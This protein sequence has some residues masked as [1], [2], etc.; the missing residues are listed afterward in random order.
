MSELLFDTG[1]DE[2]AFG[3][4]N[5]SALLNERGFIASANSAI[6]PSM[7]FSFRQWQFD[8][9]KTGVCALDN[10]AQN[11]HTHNTSSEHAHVYFCGAFDGSKTILDMLDKLRAAHT[12]NSDDALFTATRAVFAACCALGQALRENIP[13]AQIGAGGIFVHFETG[14]ARTE[15]ITL[16]FL[17]AKLFDTASACKG[18]HTYAA[19]QGAWCSKLLTDERKQLLFTQSAIAYCALT[20]HAPFS[21]IDE[22]ERHADERDKQFLRLEHAVNGIHDEVARAVDSALELPH[23][24]SSSAQLVQAAFPLEKLYAELGIGDGN[25]VA[26]PRPN[27]LPENEFKKNVAAYYAAKTRAV[28]RSR[29]IRRNTTLIAGI[30]I[31]CTVAVLLAIL[32]HAG[33]GSKPTARGLASPNVVELFYKGMHT[34]N[35]EL[36]SAMSSGKA[37]RRYTNMVSSMYVVNKARSAYEPTN[38]IVTPEAWLL[39]QSGKTAIDERAVFG[40]TSFVLD[41]NV[42]LLH[43]E[44][45]TRTMKMQPVV[46]EGGVQLADGTEAVHTA[47]Y[48]TVHTAGENNDF[49]VTCNSDTVTLTYKN[50]QW[51]VTDVATRDSDVLVDNDA[52]KAAVIESFAFAN[53]NAPRA[54]NLLREQ[55]AWIPYADV[56]AAAQDA[57]NNLS[58]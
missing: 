40:I 46:V 18:T 57:K 25:I 1:L 16:L 19:A 27:A 43:S 28:K 11:A 47:E 53:G 56:V 20:H 55:F 6:S 2:R 22:T 21:A 41:G 9:V 50:K 12:P 34:Q 39:L 8:G 26:V 13:I 32:S 42:S 58:Y 15:K 44:A 38:S 24:A 29:A 17:P 30:A 14:S 45:P 36:V 4:S 5:F 48:Y 7:T 10:N 52:F 35:V 51:R 49:I 37:A 33:N 3:K 54:A 31:A 23:A